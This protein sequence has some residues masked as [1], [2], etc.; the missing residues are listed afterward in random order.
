MRQQPT[1][2]DT[3]SAP[4]Q[5]LPAAYT[6]SL[7]PADRT[8]KCDLCDAFG[9]LGRNCPSVRCHLCGRSGHYQSDCPQQ[10][11][12]QQ[13]PRHRDAVCFI[14]GSP[15]HAQRACPS[16]AQEPECFQ[17]HERGHVMNSCPQT[18][19]FNCGTFGHSAQVCYSKAHCYNCSGSGHRSRSCPLREVGP[20]CY[21][22]RE[23]GHRAAA[24]PLGQLCRMCH[25]PGHLVAH[26]PAVTCNQCHAKGHT[27]GVC[28]E[29]HYQD[30]VLS[31][32]EIETEAEAEAEAVPAYVPAPGVPQQGG[33]VS[34]I[35]DGAYF[36]RIVRAGGAV[37]SPEHCRATAAALQHTLAF[38]ADIFT[39]APV[40]H[41]FDTDPAAY[42]R[43]I[44]TGVPI[45]RREAH[46]RERAVRQRFLTGE[47]RVG[48]ALPNVVARLVGGMKRQRGYTQDGPGHVWVQTGLDVAMATCL[49]QHFAEREMFQ[50]VVLL[51]GD[52]DLFPAVHYC[53]S[54][55][56]AGPL[57][58][59]APVRVCGTSRSVAKVF[60]VHQDTFDFLPSILLD[61][62]VHAEAGREHPFPTSSAFCD[63]GEEEDTDDCYAYQV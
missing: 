39:L 5:L 2:L 11:P 46:F 21:Q 47:M 31:P 16:K 63:E 40:A 53:N 27:A 50:Q 59:R 49:I 26:C 15:Q 25:R 51:C 18:R 61:R 7:P 6:R 44:E 32:L 34:V 17:C 35:I 41:W 57:A 8:L 20:V 28:P 56:R 13:Q 37:G 42:G 9:H 58:G 23:P 14:C 60:G 24:C 62:A 54:L 3:V 45:A 22:C 36:E 38:I 52:G 12:Q 19:C 29:T 43:F 48:G 4:P 55:R 30:P 1:Q 10:P 33:R